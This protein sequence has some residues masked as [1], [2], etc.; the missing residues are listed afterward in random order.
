MAK[1]EFQEEDA[2]ARSIAWDF[3]DFLSSPYHGHAAY[4]YHKQ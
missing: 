3:R 4:Y 1:Q 2:F